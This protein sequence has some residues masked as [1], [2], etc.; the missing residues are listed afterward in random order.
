[1]DNRKIKA[2]IRDVPDF[3]KPGII[4]KDITP[5]LLDPN[6]FKAVIGLFVKRHK[7]KRID[8]IAAIDARG[9]LFGGALAEKLGVGLVPIRKKGKLP[10]K[11][12][13]ETYDLEY[14]TA[15][16]SIHQ[17]AF[18]K[19]ERVVLIDDLLATGGT[20]AAAANLIRKAGGKVVEIDFLV[21]L[22]FLKGRRKLQGYK[23]FAPIKY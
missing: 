3:P 17:D 9:F 21:E 7:G 20:A 1:M 15:T 10:Y 14:G 16:I 2:A 18:K 8:K 19:G 13:E 6:L 11:T 5:V 22:A 4:F 23:I 12:F